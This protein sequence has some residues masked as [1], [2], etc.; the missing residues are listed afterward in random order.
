MRLLFLIG[1]HAA[2]KMT[3]GQALSALTPMKLFHNH[4]TI[5]PVIA[6]F[7]CY[8]GT[9][10]Q[11]LREVV[12]EE[13]ART[14]NYGLI[15][16]FVWGFSEQADWDYVKHVSGLFR[17][18]GAQVD[19][20]ELIAPQEVRLIRNRTE[21]RLREKFSKRDVALSEQLFL[22]AEKRYRCVSEPGEIVA[23]LGIAEER[24]LRIENEALSPEQA[25][26]MIAS[27]FGYERRK[28]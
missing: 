21:N 19:Y 24:Y 12:F 1:A 11:R 6:L 3:V 4:M 15:F 5:E 9:V 23:G 26:E 2:G 16:T 18:A 25:A 27:H 17:E 14:D 13:F 20:V 22:S 10:T 7:G 28:A 8:N